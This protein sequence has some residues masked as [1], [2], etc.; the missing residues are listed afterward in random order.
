MAGEYDM[1]VATRHGLDG[2]SNTV[3]A[4][5]FESRFDEHFDA[6]Y[7]HCFRL[8]AS[9]SAAEDAA[10]AT[11]LVAWRKRGQIRLVNGSALPWLLTVATNEVRNQRRSLRRWLHAAHRAPTDPV[12][13]DHADDVAE[14]LHDEAQMAA[15]LRAVRRLPRAEREALALCVWAGLGYADVAAA[16]GIAA[17]SVRSRVSRARSRLTSLLVSTGEEDQ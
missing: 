12:V 4:A 13:Q 1:S 11:F 9:W 15:L 10:Q 5:A 14:R 7:Q 2:D 16:L 8:T 6:V 17:A 3:A